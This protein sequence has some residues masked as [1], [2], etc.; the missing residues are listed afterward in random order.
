MTL[1][2]RHA[3]YVAY[4]KMKVEEEDWHGVSD[5]ANDLREL[6]AE[7][8][9]QLQPQERTQSLSQKDIW[10]AVKRQLPS[11]TPSSGTLS[12]SPSPD[13]TISPTHFGGLNEL[14]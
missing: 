9:C 1:T 4:L 7:I 11:Q 12:P 8:G 14:V 6:E 13:S 2:E 10:E 5:A 3:V